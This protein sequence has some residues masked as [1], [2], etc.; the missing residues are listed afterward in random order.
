MSMSDGAPDAGGID[1]P[2]DVDAAAE[3]ARNTP[4][5]DMAEVLPWM[6]GDTTAGALGGP[7]AEGR[8]GD[9]ADGWV[10]IA[11]ARSQLEAQMIVATLRDVE[12]DALCDEPMLLP[13]DDALRQR[14]M[15]V[16]VRVPARQERAAQTALRRHVEQARGIDWDSVDVGQRVDSIVG[17]TPGGVPVLAMAVAVLALIGLATMAVMAV[18]GLA[19]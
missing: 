18:V 9:S 7:S 10:M 3:W 19:R 14:R 8:R 5:P 15:R 6:A 1:G 16:Q 17:R 13:L 4:E 12:I 11:S 2:T